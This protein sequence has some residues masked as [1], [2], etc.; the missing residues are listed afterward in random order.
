[1]MITRIIHLLFNHVSSYSICHSVEP[2]KTNKSFRKN[3]L[4]QFRKSVK[5]SE[6]DEERKEEEEKEKEEEEEA[7]SASNSKVDYK[8]SL[9]GQLTK[10]Q[11]TQSSSP[12]DF[13]LLKSI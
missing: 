2:C 9:F 13:S 5:G 12:N 8:R 7:K 6:K 4:P 3:P 10:T 11:V 1:M